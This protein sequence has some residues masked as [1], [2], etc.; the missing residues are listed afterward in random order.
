VVG[1]ADHVQSVRK[2]DYALLALQHLASGGASGVA[3]ARAIA[4]RFNIPAELLAK[5]P[6]TPPDAVIPVQGR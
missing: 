5:S 1:D 2:A 6:A 4:E 3:S